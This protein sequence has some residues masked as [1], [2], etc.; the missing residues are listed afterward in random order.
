MQRIWVCS[1]PFSGCSFSLARSCDPAWCG[2]MVRARLQRCPRGPVLLRG[3]EVLCSPPP[4]SRTSPGGQRQAPSLWARPRFSSRAVQL[5]METLA[6]PALVQPIETCPE[7]KK[8]SAASLNSTP[9][10]HK[11]NDFEKQRR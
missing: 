2:H 10:S 4:L 8:T 3:A 6:E 11:I 7:T 5:S 9:Q 1:L